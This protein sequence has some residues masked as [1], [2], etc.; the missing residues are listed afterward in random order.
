MKIGDFEK[1]GYFCKRLK[2]RF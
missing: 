2:R 1:D